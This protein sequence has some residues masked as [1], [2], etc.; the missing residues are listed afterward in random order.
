[1]PSSDAGDIQIFSL[2][3][4][5]ALADRDYAT[6]HSMTS[7]EFKSRYS[8]DQ[9]RENFETIVPTDGEQL[10]L[11]MWVRFCRNGRRKRHLIL[12]GSTSL[13]EAMFIAKPSRL[14]SRQ[15]TVCSRFARWN[16]AG[17]EG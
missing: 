14:F 8:I 4:T 9:L 12:P 11:S 2:N 5:K 7:D 1:M 13:S 6:A 16:M 15:R 10:T 3:F 17:P